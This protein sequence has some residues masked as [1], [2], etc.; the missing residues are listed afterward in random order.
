[1]ESRREHRNGT[2]RYDGDGGGDDGGGDSVNGDDVDRYRYY[3]WSRLRSV[4]Y[5]CAEWR[6]LSLRCVFFNCG[7]CFSLD[8]IF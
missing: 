6:H 7:D 8:S 3:C 5:Q 2:S 4:M 1:M